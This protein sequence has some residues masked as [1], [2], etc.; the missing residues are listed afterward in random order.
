MQ[1]SGSGRGDQTG[2][3]DRCHQPDQRHHRRGRH[4]R[5]AGRG[6]QR[7]SDGQCRRH[8]AHGA[9]YLLRDEVRH[10]ER[11]DGQPEG[12]ARRFGDGYGHNGVRQC[13]LQGDGESRAPQHQRNAD[14]CRTADRR[15]HADFAQVC[16]QQLRWEL[17]L[18]EWRSVHRHRGCKR[19]GDG[20]LQGQGDHLCLRLQSAQQARKG[21]RHGVRP[22]DGHRYS[23]GNH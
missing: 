13:E 8:A 10:R 18:S 6:V 20:R 3:G 23:R 9:V 2:A 21:H 19:R 14:Q 22:G 16:Q 15:D 1:V 11:C 5:H 4:G 7:R 17:H 12:R